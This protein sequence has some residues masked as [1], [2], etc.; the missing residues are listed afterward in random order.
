[1]YTFSDTV[2][3]KTLVCS[4]HLCVPDR[5][6]DVKGDLV[7][8]VLGNIVG[9]RTPVGLDALGAIRAVLQRTPRVVA[10]VS[11]RYFEGRCSARVGARATLTVL[12]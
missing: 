7:S 4:D 10:L 8:S 11:W 12:T 5:R 3:R 6:H 2:D 1:M 9:S